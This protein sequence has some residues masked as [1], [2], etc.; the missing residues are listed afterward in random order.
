MSDGHWRLEGTA[1][2]LFA[3]SG[4]SA[5]QRARAVKQDSPVSEQSRPVQTILGIYRKLTADERQK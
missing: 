1:A 5:P 4:R 2:E 3:P